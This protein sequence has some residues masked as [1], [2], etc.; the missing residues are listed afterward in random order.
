MK[1]H[2]IKANHPL[3]FW[4][5]VVLGLLLTFT[6]QWIHETGHWLIL[7]SFGRDP[8]WGFTRLVQVWGE[9]P[10]DPQTWERI[11]SPAGEVGWLKLDAL[12]QTRLE[13]MLFAMAGPAASLLGLLAGLWLMQRAAHPG[14]RHFGR[15]LALTIS[16]GMSLYYLRA[17]WRTGGDEV[18]FARA[19]GIAPWG[20]NLSLALLFLLGLVLA[21]RA[22]PDWKSRGKCTAAIF[23]GSTMAGVLLFF[24]D[25]WV[26]KGILAGRAFFQPLLGF[27]LPVF[28][29]NSF[30]TGWGV[31]L[32]LVRQFPQ[33]QTTNRNKKETIE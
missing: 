15:G 17:P 9:T 20:V 30:L 2:T 5:L 11:E 24:L 10:P 25:Q 14:W 7:R 6:S 22:L 23:L 16:L 29:V 19:A 8:V 12:P 21:L 4:A 1:R 26:L 31:A 13:E 28:I 32:L 33:E 3:S 27:S 18:N